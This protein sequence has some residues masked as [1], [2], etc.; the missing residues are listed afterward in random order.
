MVVSEM[1]E[2]EKSFSLRGD[3]HKMYDLA[4]KHFPTHGFSLESSQYPNR[5]VFK[6]KG[7]HLTRNVREIPQTLQLTLLRNKN[8]TITII[9]TYIFH[10]VGF[11]TS[12]GERNLDSDITAFKNMILNLISKSESIECFN[13]GHKNPSGSNYCN[14][15]GE[16]LDSTRIY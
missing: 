13:C 10:T 7:T 4:K 8:D 16:R 12:N 14:N 6:K 5:L 9:M 1:Q 15:C 2:Y 11:L 3:I